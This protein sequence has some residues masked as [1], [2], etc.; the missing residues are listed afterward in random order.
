MELYRFALSCWF[1][2]QLYSMLVENI[3]RSEEVLQQPA[4]GIFKIDHEA[5]QEFT[6]HSF[7]RL[8]TN[9][10]ISYS[11][12]DIFKVPLNYPKPKVTPFYPSMLYFH[13]YPMGAYGNFRIFILSHRQGRSQPRT[14]PGSASLHDIGS[15]PL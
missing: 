11:Y 12:M 5:K 9:R 3:F 7:I 8:Q 4:Q 14:L 10:P 13:G 2:N 15:A 1:E 6:M